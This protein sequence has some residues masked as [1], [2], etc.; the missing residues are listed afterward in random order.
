MSSAPT[1]R[2]PPPSTVRWATIASRCCAP[3]PPI[4]V[5][6]NVYD[7]ATDFGP[8]SEPAEVTLVGGDIAVP[9]SVNGDIEVSSQDRVTTY[10]VDVDYS[11]DAATG[12]I[13]RIAAGGIPAANTTLSVRTRQPDPV[14]ASVANVIGAD[15]A[16]ARTGVYALLDAESV[17][18]VRLGILVAPDYSGRG[19]AGV[20]GVGL[21]LGIVNA[22]L[23]TNFVVDMT[24][25]A[26]S[27]ADAIA[28]RD[29]YDD[30]KGLGVWP[31]VKADTP[32]G[33]VRDEPASLHIAAVIAAN[34]LDPN[35]GY[36]WSPSNRPLPLVRGTVTP[37]SFGPADASADATVLD[38]EQVM[39]IVNIGGR[40]RSWG[41][42]GLGDPATAGRRQHFAVNRVA[43]IVEE[44]LR[45]HHLQYV[46]VPSAEVYWSEV[47]GGVNADLRDMRNLGAIR[48]GSCTRSD[49][50]T[51]ATIDAGEAIWDIV[52]DPPP[53]MKLLR[54]RIRVSSAGTTAFV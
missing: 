16:G 54:F 12:T 46:D 3:R 43:G 31:W 48:S 5:A 15:V 10:V 44:T 7:P 30:V 33:T 29:L 41:N 47:E 19:G 37:V 35:R 32:A 24:D 20:R 25:E 38:G 50:N 51:Q 21:A 27:R 26:G 1:R 42:A 22:R 14:G 6:I 2:R 9:A 23:N 28:A 36:W 49:L 45:R 52:I 18:R 53:P 13:T 4:V 11:F 34:D 40:A 17:T 39:T 8:W